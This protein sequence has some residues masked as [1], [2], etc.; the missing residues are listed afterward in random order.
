MTDQNWSFPF[1]MQSVSAYII[2]I[3][4]CGRL[5]WLT[6]L[7]GPAL[8]FALGLRLQCLQ[9]SRRSLGTLQNLR[10]WFSPWRQLW[11]ISPMQLSVRGPLYS[12]SCNVG[13]LDKAT[14]GLHQIDTNQ[15]HQMYPLFARWYCS[16]WG[17]FLKP[18]SF[19]LN[20]GWLVQHQYLCKMTDSA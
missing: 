7:E 15:V 11:W 14:L 12:A 9:G 18:S 13:G 20:Y 6:F 16:L 3:V 5:L 17:L 19:L 8:F 1:V 4:F 2:K 10:K